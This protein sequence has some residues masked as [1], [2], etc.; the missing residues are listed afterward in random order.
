[1]RGKATSK[2][3][4]QGMATHANKAAPKAPRLPRTKDSVKS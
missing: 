3:L 2:D 4:T 1:M